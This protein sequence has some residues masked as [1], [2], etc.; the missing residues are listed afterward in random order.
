M[1][2]ERLGLPLARLFDFRAKSFQS[3]GIGIMC[4]EF[5]SMD[6]APEFS[7]EP[8]PKISVPDIVSSY[9]P[10][11]IREEAYKALADEGLQ[12]MEQVIEREINLLSS[13]PRFMCLT[14]HI[15]ESTLRA[16]RLA[17]VHEQ[18]A[19][20]LKMESTQKLSLDFIKLQWSTLAQFHELD[21]EAAPIQADGIPILCND[22]PPIPVNL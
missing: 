21:I 8:L 15:Y 7:R 9:K 19:A 12:G 5:V 22:V 2:Y 1:Q 13:T 20:A 17:P 14:R 6:L 11:Q 18:K 3:R 10:N 16:I 4:E